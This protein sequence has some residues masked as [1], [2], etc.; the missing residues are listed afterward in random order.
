MRA[1]ADTLLLTVSPTRRQYQDHLDCQPNPRLANTALVTLH[2][3]LDPKA[4]FDAVMAKKEKK[5]AAC[6]GGC[7]ERWNA[8]PPQMVR[9]HDA[10]SPPVLPTDYVDQQRNATSDLRITLTRCV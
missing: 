10:L 9:V 2:P 4:V 7:C 8:G 5:L 1:Y 3:H 6:D